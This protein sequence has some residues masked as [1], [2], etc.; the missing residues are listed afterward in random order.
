MTWKKYIYFV[1]IR[2]LIVTK[3]PYH[4]EGVY[5]VYLIVDENRIGDCHQDS[6]LDFVQFSSLNLACLLD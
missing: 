6:E 1:R 4:I 2:F 5:C 3:E